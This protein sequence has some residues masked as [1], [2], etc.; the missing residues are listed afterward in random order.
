[1]V[2]PPHYLTSGIT[3]WIGNSLLG[4]RRDARLFISIHC[5]NSDPFQFTTFNCFTHLLRASSFAI[6]CDLTGRLQLLAPM[7][8]DY[9]KHNSQ[10]AGILLDFGPTGL[11]RMAKGS[12]LRTSVLAEGT[13][14]IR[15][16][17][18]ST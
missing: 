16:T 9:R 5:F 4:R 13:S 11:R 15:K 2:I 1:M 7:V 14:F 17:V 3:A 8:S 6:Q 18:G 10:R 12:R